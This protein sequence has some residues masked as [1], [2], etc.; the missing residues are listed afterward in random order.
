MAKGYEKGKRAEY[1][2]QRILEAAFGLLRQAVGELFFER[3]VQG[4]L[5]TR[6]GRDRRGGGSASGRALKRRAGASRGP[7]TGDLEHLAELLSVVGPVNVRCMFGG[8]GI[9]AEDLMIALTVD[10]VVF[11]KADEYSIPDFEREGLP[12]FRY[13]TKNGART[14]ASFWRMPERLYDEPD[15]LARWAVLA[16]EA[17]KRAGLR[18]ARRGQ[19][20]QAASARRPRSAR[21][22]R[23]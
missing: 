13:Q 12:P 16:L 4:G 6:T 3:R 15:E 21:K 8:A 18:A 5:A 19:P 22:P 2:A 1:R 20:R 23:R 9:F 11:L 10:G 17:A 14:I 7:G